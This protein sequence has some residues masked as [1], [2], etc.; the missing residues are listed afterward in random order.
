MTSL[1]IG[2]RSIGRTLVVAAIA[3]LAAVWALVGVGAA[4]AHAA[5][6]VTVSGTLTADTE[7]TIQVSGSGFQSV[8]GGFGGI[9]VLFGWVDDPAGGSWTPSAGG[10]TGEDYRYVYDDESNPVGYQ[11]FVTF[12]GS[13]TA[14]AANGGEV[15]ADGTWSGTMR[16][17]SAVFQTFDRDLNE[18]T[19]NCLEVQCGVITIGAHGVK[20]ANN[21]SFTPVSFPAPAAGTGTAGDAGA[22]A[23]ETNDEAAP[24]QSEEVAAAPVATSA[25]ITT[26]T[27]PAAQPLPDWLLVLLPV[28]IVA[29]LAI[30]A[31]AV[32]VGAY[33]AAKSLLLG[34]NPAALE[35]VRGQRERRAIRERE[36]QRR[37][38]ATLRRAQE[39][40]SAR[41]R[42]R[43]DGAVARQQL[44]RDPV[45]VADSA[46]RMNDFFA[47]EVPP[48]TPTSG[49]VPP[50][51]W[52]ETV[53]A[54]AGGQGGS[55]PAGP[56]SI[57]AEAESGAGAA[58]GAGTAPGDDDPAATRQGETSPTYLAAVA[59]D[60][61]GTRT[62]GADGDAPTLVLAAA[63]ASTSAPNEAATRGTEEER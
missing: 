42:Q 16:V 61:D 63:R 19:V 2:A 3:A 35:K 20:N 62:G 9:Y 21:E 52:F 39:L 55:S 40:R 5:G 51:S 54:N 24:E 29:G 37:K 46:D 36:K 26:V 22:T 33:L 47:A 1:S 13:S 11:L 27:T 38:T 49:D 8:Q 6:Q 60:A 14:Y 15:A 43:V 50:T 31:L 7:S 41:A 25:P 57:G 28:L 30:V 56:D 32:G 45:V 10:V 58:G 44:E 18:T 17:P 48:S 12:P 34:V 23:G 59:D 53:A 4:P